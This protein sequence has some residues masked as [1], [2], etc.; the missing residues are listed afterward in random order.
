MHRIAWSLAALAAVFIPSA[1]RADL[2]VVATV[3]D[4]AAL[5]KEVGGARVR[6]RTLALPTQ[7][8]HY[9]DAKPSLALALN[10]ADLLLAVG[11]DLEI[12]WLPTLQTGARNPRIQVGADGFLDC[13]QFVTPLDVPVGPVDRSKGDI[14]PRGNPHYLTDPRAA[15]A[16]ARGIAARMAQL[17]PDGAADYRA[18]LAAFTRRLAAARRGWEAR[19][20]KWSGRSVV[21]YH[22]SFHY[23]TDWLRLSVVAYLEPKPGVKPSPGHVAKVIA[24][25]RRQRVRAVLLEDYYPAATAKLAAAKMGAK[26]IVVPGGAHVDDGQTYIQRM[27][28][29]V[30]LLE[31]ALR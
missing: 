1:A 29:V 12:G 5:A 24:L 26:L 4:L 8:P 11:L 13:S 21:P 15:E 27:D 31:E 23:L 2:D 10:R 9:V 28:Q 6:V 22:N 16:V 3:P 14:H 20:A 7:D 19:A 30:G 17:D 18:N 25:G